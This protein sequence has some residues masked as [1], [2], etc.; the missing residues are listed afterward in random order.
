MHPILRNILAG[1]GGWLIGSSVN[2]GIIQLGYK[3]KPLDG[4]DTNDMEVL[5]AAMPNL[6]ASYFIFPFLAHALGT[7]VGALAAGWIAGTHKMMIA[8]SIGVL[9][10]I[11]GIMV[12]FML[13]APTW[14]IALDLIVA[15][16]PMAWLGGKVAIKLS[17]KSSPA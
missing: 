17:E 11:F 7:F 9:F 4:V 12:S 3:L 5:A 8:L 10:L 6:D 2:M 13:P 16:I 15:Y 1:I 14:F